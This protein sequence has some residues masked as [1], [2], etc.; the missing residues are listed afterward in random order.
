[1]ALR[2][3]PPKPGAAA[4]WREVAGCDPPMRER[5]AAER[6]ATAQALGNALQERVRRQVLAHPEARR[7]IFTTVKGGTRADQRGVERDGSTTHG[8]ALVVWAQAACALDR[9]DPFRYVTMAHAHLLQGDKREAECVLLS[10][11]KRFAGH[12]GRFVLW[13]NLGVVRSVLRL[14][15]GALEAYRAAACAP[16]RV[17]RVVAAISLCIVGAK[18]RSTADVELGARLLSEADIVDAPEMVRA[19]LAARRERGNDPYWGF[20]E[21]DLRALA[22]GAPGLCVCEDWRIE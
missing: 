20:D 22:A 7:V 11:L 8:R 1:M 16:G 14:P 3:D 5:T 19:A 12:S 15:L 6:R 13:Q 9:D 10:A 2:A 18:L 21:G 17:D 4:W